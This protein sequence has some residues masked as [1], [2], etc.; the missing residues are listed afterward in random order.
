MQTGCCWLMVT[1]DSSVPLIIFCLVLLLI[2]ERGTLRLSS[3]MVHLSIFLSS[4]ISFCS[5][6]LQFCC[7]MHIHLGSLYCLG[8]LTLLSSCSVLLSLI[9]FAL[10]P[11]LSIINIVIPSFSLS[12][13]FYGLCTKNKY[14]YRLKV[15]GW[16]N[17]SCKY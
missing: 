13:F 7:L 12:S 17:I 2:A 4:S 6:I 5:Y 1:L 14:I 10:K 16:E 3:I 9:S 15:K 8:G 11:A